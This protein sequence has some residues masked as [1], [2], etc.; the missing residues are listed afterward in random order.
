[1]AS[2]A[3]PSIHGELLSYSG[4]PA[5]NVNIPVPAPANGG[6]LQAVQLETP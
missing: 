2:V 3:L 6:G 5:F 1:M 4:N